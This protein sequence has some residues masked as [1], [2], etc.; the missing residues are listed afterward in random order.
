MTA[1]F[2]TFIGNMIAEVQAEVNALP[3]NTPQ[4]IAYTQTL[5]QFRRMQGR[6][7]FNKPWL[8]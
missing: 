1:W 4:L 6:V 3:L 8:N 2:Q 7:S 5:N